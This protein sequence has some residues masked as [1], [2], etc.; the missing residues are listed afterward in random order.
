MPETVTVPVE[1]VNWCLWPPLP[2]PLVKAMLPA[3][4]MPAPTDMILILF[5]CRGMVI[6]PETVRVIPEL[7]VTIVLAV[8]A[9]SYVIE[10]HAAVAV[11][12]TVNPPPILTTSPATGN[13][14]ALVAL[15]KLTVDQV[16]LEFQ[17][18]IALEKYV[19]AFANIEAARKINVSAILDTP[20]LRKNVFIKEV[21]CGTW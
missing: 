8:L 2:P 5:G 14:P 1:I 12:V 9:T 3:F 13:V 15:T 11:T 19:V 10:A 20:D 6:A 17:L 18:P 7:M 16:V 4:K 21:L